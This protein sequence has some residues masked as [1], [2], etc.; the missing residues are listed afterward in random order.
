MAK[1]HR[2]VKLND[3][4]DSQ[5]FT[6][7]LPAKVATDTISGTWSKDIVYGYHKWTVSFIRNDSH[8]GCFL[9]WLSNCG[10]MKC[11]IDFSFTLLNREHFTRNET[12]IEK[13]FV[14]TT[15]LNQHGRQ[16]FVGL[17][18]LLEKDFSQVTGDYLIEL[19]MRKVNCV[20][21]SY[22]RLPREMQSRYAYETKLESAYFSFGLFDW[23]IS[24]IPSEGNMHQDENIIIQLHRHTS[25]DH[26][27]NVR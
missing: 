8:L 7:E 6:F 19:E 20:F 23:S 9:K 22:I 14:F 10:G 16:T 11:Q 27:C 24:L 1:L 26:L 4:F 21:E 15:E 17:N 25:F 12:F 3:R 5:I 13:G 2:F 18:D